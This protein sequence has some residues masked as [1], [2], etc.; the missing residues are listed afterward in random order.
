MG[1]LPGSPNV[2]VVYRFATNATLAKIGRAGAVT[3]RLPLPLDSLRRVLDDMVVIRRARR[4]TQ[5]SPARPHAQ[6]ATQPSERIRVERRFDD[7]QLARLLEV[8]TAIDCECPNHL[9]SLVTGLVAFEQYSR[10][11]ESRDEQDAAQHRRLAEGTAEARALME[12]L[13]VE[14]CEHEGI[15]V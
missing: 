8:S 10:E 6:A 9:S 2:L 4:L 12:Q 1:D 7:A 14:L 5:P 13:L 11:C 3:S 15:Q